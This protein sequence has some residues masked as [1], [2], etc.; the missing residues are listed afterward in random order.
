MK[1]LD[2]L[3]KERQNRNLPLIPDDLWRWT[4]TCKQRGASSLWSNGLV[5]TMTY[6]VMNIKF[7]SRSA[8]LKWASAEFLGVVSMCG[9][10]KQ[11]KQS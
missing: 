6:R 2:D 9:T 7:R 11:A 10:A 5:Y 8:L 4:C 1:V 3:N